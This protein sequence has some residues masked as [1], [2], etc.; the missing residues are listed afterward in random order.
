[1]KYSNEDLIFCI[2]LVT[3]MT[4]ISK[5]NLMGYS[6]LI[7]SK[8]ITDFELTILFFASDYFTIPLVRQIKRVNAVY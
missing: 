4:N 2:K 3:G 7:Y 5:K 1:M 6:K 8:S